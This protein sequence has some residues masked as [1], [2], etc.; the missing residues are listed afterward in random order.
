MRKRQR[1]QRRMNVSIRASLPILLGSCR[2]KMPGWGAG[3]CYPAR[4][5]QCSHRRIASTLRPDSSPDCCVSHTN[6]LSLASTSILVAAIVIPSVQSPPGFGRGLRVL[7]A[8]CDAR[9]APLDY[10]AMDNQLAA[11]DD[12]AIDNQLC[13]RD[14]WRA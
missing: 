11:P 5:K 1:L 6:L 14:R 8:G 3:G 7:P 13:S 10:P 4:L 9:P 2:L 12:C